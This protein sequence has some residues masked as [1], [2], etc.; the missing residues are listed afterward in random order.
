MKRKTIALFCAVIFAC[1]APFL[2]YAEE[3]DIKVDDEVVGK[4]I[5]EQ[6][7]DTRPAGKNSGQTWYTLN[8]ENT[9]GYNVKVNVIPKGHGSEKESDMPIYAYDE[10]SFHFALDGAPSG[11]VIEITK[12][13]K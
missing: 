2:T 10:T 8:V 11:W 6:R 9:S 7:D 3:I 12:V 4:L 5:Y 1:F 13:Y